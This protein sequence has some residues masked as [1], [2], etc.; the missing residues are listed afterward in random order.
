[1]KINLRHL[2]VLLTLAAIAVFVYQSDLF[3]ADWRH[4]DGTC[5][6]HQEPMDT[7]VVNRLEGTINFSPQYFDAKERD[8]PNC[9][10]EY[11]KDLYGR[12]RGKIFVCPA[13]EKN[14]KNWLNK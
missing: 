13:C 7:V 10:I 3:V 12:E 9:G 1:M 5:T 14:R 11:S 8:F 4:G 6:V 2:F